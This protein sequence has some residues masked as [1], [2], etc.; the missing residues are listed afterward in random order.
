MTRYA[1]IEKAL[2]RIR[3]KFTSSNSIPVERA[4]V[5]ASEWNELEAA[6]ALPED[7]KTVNA[8]LYGLAVELA[9]TYARDG[10]ELC[11]DVSPDG[12]SYLRNSYPSGYYGKR[13][14]QALRYLSLREAS[15][16]P[17]PYRV[18]L[19]GDKVRFE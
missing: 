5:L 10:V 18:V 2:T 7:S 6:L 15:G 12:Q 9:D 14:E 16:E 8:E 4:V 3:L 11:C 1:E 17:M 13:A 19:D